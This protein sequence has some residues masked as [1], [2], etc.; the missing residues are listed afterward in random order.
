MN[1]GPW[2]IGLVVLLALVTLVCC[3]IL[4]IWIVRGLRRPPAA[5]PRRPPVTR[6]TVVLAHGLL[7]F[8]EMRLAGQR[9]EYFRGLAD[10]LQGLGSEVHCPRV[11]PVGEGISLLWRPAFEFCTR[12]KWSI[13]RWPS[14]HSMR[15]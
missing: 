2:L 1:S 9:L 3:T 14:G 8:D 6:P 11:P 7:G 5:A 12:W 13:M 4:T 10:H 15:R